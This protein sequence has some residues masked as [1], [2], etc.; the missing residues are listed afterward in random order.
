[1]PVQQAQRVL[2]AC[3]LEQLERRHHVSNYRHIE[4]P[5]KYVRGR[6]RAPGALRCEM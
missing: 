6:L 1:V 2:D 3:R 4:L 5:F